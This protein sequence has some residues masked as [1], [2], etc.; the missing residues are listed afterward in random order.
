MDKFAIRMYS[1]PPFLVFE[2]ML[3]CVGCYHAVSTDVQS[4]VIL[5]ENARNLVARLV[6]NQNAYGMPQ[7][8]SPFG[9]MAYTVYNSKHPCAFSCHAPS[10]CPE[11]EPCTA[12]VEQTCPCGHVRSRTTCSAC[13]SNPVARETVKLKCVQECAQRQRNARLAEAL[14]IKPT[15]RLVEYPPELKVF[16]T[17]NLQFVVTVEKAFNDFFMGPKQATLLPHTPAQKRQFVLSL[18]EIYR[19]GTE[20]V[21]AEPNTSVQLRRRIDSRIPNPLL[22]SVTT[23]PVAR[24]QLGGLGDLRKPAV[25]GTA[26]PTTVWG[27]GRLSRPPSPPK[28]APVAGSSRPTSQPSLAGATGLVGLS[29]S[30]PGLGGLVA[31]KPKKEVEENA[32]DWDEDD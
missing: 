30:R 16:A 15:E 19:F 4:L 7:F 23:P 3:W 2:L 6:E 8:L 14:G 17:N 13:T 20:L 31:A 1:I 21:D 5:Q 29:R 26:T 22:S 32:K 12:Q 10:C 24:R 27:S 25:G 18:A 11:D 28:S 9:I